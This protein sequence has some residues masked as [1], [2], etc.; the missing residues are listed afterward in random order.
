MSQPGI[1]IV[2]STYNSPAFL[3]LVLDGYRKQT[4]LSFSI[5]IAD[6]G[7]GEET[8][9]LIARHQIDFPVPIKHIWHEDHGFRKARIHNITIQTI[10][11]PYVLLTDGDCIPLPGM[12]ETH[13]RFAKQ[14]NLI[15]GGRV[16]L[17]QPWTES[18]SKRE[19]NFNSGE[20]FTGWLTHRLKKN[21]NRI[22]P[23]I[24]P[25]HLG[26]SNRKLKG[27]RGCH[28]S[29]WL[30]DLHRINGFDESYEGWGRE[31]SDLI[32]RLFHAGIYRLD[33]RG[34]PVLHL[35]HR[36]EARGQLS[37]NDQLL[38]ECLKNRRIEAVKGLR[39]L[40]GSS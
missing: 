22:L 36:E 9:E 33:L 7:S 31:D 13:R 32:A 24:T 23:I 18:I 26:K 30:D 5:Y 19:V 6:D 10:G 17:S 4:D 2:I 14:G 3:Q 16:L 28:I 40:Q 11:E 27:I 39:E 38:A 15:S 37:R 12:V 20:T 29:C 1:A 21:I 25:P 35:W 8:K 34:M